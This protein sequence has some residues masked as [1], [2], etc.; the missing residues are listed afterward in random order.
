MSQRLLFAAGFL[1]LVM[2]VT[3]PAWGQIV[4]PPLEDPAAEATPVTAAAPASTAAAPGAVRY[5]AAL[6]GR[7]VSIPSWFLGLFTKQNVPLSS[8]GFGGEFVRRKGPMDIVVGLNYQD[9]SPDD[10]NW[11]GRGKE[12]AANTDFVQFR[13]LGFV[14][15][16][17]SFMWRQTFNDY[18]GAHY[19]AGL[20]FALVTGKILRISAAGCTEANAG[21][22][23]ACRPRVCPAS[24]CTESI[25]RATEGATDT[26]P[27]NP[28]RFS[29]PSVPGAIP[30]VNML[31]GL[32]LRLPELPGL[33]F[34]LE[35]G[36]YNAFFLGLTTGYMF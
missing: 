19:G 21:D 13:N 22:E 26:G 28:H 24:G 15:V 9:M 31:V 3:T 25:L 12:A 6:R 1:G 16:D 32:N 18:L 7:L 27:D 36:F 2:L 10:G 33:E 14:G 11:L 8:Y 29:E 5:G 35:G 17:A 23:R 34:K 20:G 4:A 30:I